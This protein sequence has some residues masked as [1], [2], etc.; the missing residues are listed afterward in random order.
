MTTRPGSPVSDEPDTQLPQEGSQTGP[1]WWRDRSLR[2]W[3]T[4]MVAAFGLGVAANTVAIP[5]VIFEPGPAIDVLGTDSVDGEDRLRIQIEQAP[6][7]PTTGELDFTTVLLRGGP[8]RSVTAVDVLAAWLD[9]ESDVYDYEQIYPP[10]VTREE[11]DELVRVQMATSQ[12]TS[13]VV[14]LRALGYQVPEIITVTRVAEGAPSGDVLQVGDVLVSMAGRPVDDHRVLREGIEQAIAGTS[15]EVVV[16]RAGQQMTLHPMTGTADDGRTILGIVLGVDY[17]LPFPV[18]IDAD[19]VGGSSAGLMFS[20][21]V[22]DRLTEGALTGGQRIAGTGT[23]NHLGQVG[24]IGGIA[25][26]L[27]GARRAGADY[28]LAPA[29]NCAEVIGRE[30][31]GLTVVPVATFE[32]ARHAVTEI[33]D[34]H[35]ADLPRC[36]TTDSPP[37]H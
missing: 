7:Y 17:E 8:G 5:Y 22:Y 24:P 37:G 33:A 9:P 28:F 14:A 32:Q 34:G 3:L 16:E 26:K 35:A 4:G 25:Q 13:A 29:D 31:V 18:T 6:T 19:R 10:Q 36:A 20:L 12:Q 15:I 11:V 23:I 21:G 2:R 30:P 1:P 27:V